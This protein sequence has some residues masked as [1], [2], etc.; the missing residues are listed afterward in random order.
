MRYAAAES[1][2]M[3]LI[4]RKIDKTGGTRYGI[5]QEKTGYRGRRQ[6]KRTE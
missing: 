6:G 2:F 3:I 1:K 4:C 5:I